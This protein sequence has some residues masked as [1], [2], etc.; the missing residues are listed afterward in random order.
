MAEKLAVVAPAATVT[1]AGV[2]RAAGLLLERLTRKPP[3][4]A[5]LVKVAVQAAALPRVT[6]A[7]QLTPLS[8]TGARSVRD[9]L[10]V[11]AFLAAVIWAVTSAATAAALALNA[12]LVAPAGTVTEA[13]TVTLALL[14]NRETAMPPASAGRLSD[15]VHVEVA[16]P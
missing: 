1:E 10:R 15:T 12:A 7:G 6:L 14:E 11:I 3:P 2:A 9:V 5:P 13:G 8:C 4:G 16:G